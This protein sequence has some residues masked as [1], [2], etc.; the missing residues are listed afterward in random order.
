M[1]LQNH[2]VTAT[3][4]YIG[5]YAYFLPLEQQSLFA[6]GTYGAEYSNSCTLHHPLALDNLHTQQCDSCNYRS[7]SCLE[8]A[9]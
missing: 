2:G 3:K 6:G 8:V 5:V 1:L 9:W 4:R 7:Q